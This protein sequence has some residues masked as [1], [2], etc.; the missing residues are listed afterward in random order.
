[1]NLKSRVDVALNPDL[2]LHARARPIEFRVLGGGALDIATGVIHAEV[3]AVPVRVA[4]PFMKN[5]RVVLAAF[6]PFKVTIKPVKMTLKSSDVRAEGVI[7]GEEGI[8]ANLH[9]LG[10]CHAEVN[11]AGESDV[12]SLKASFEGVF[13]E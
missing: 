6:G 4:M 9:V 10:K 1:M 12:K 7:G 2:D 11:V 8:D 13:E 5:R 3:A